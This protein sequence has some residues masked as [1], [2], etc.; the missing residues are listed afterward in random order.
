MNSENYNKL[1]SFISEELLN[2]IQFFRLTLDTTLYEDLKVSGGDGIEFLEKFLVHFDIDY[3]EDREWQLHFGSEG[4][5][6][7]LFDYLL[8][9]FGY[10][11]KIRKQYDLTIRHLLKVVEKGYWIDMDDE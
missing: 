1:I 2:E 11:K 3:D 9:F 10:K 4:S 6:I 7:I 8:L 5:S